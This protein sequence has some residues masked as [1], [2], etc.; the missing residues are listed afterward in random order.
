MWWSL[1]TNGWPGRKYAVGSGERPSEEVEE[2]GK[3]LRWFCEVNLTDD[4]A[5]EGRLKRVKIQWLHVQIRLLRVY[6]C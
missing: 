1:G 6:S 3:L 4:R 5:L 2:G